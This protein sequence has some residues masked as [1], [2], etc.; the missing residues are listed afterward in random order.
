[1]CFLYFTSVIAGGQKARPSPLGAAAPALDPHHSPV[2]K[3]LFAPMLCLAYGKAHAF[4]SLLN[5]KGATSA[6]FGALPDAITA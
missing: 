4:L 5:K 3:E 2:L 1:M 6:T